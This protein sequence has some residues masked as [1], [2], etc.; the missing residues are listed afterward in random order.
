LVI[1]LTRDD[2]EKAIIKYVKED[3]L[4]YGR[5]GEFELKVTQGKSA[6]AKVDLV[7]IIPNIE[8]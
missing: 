1:N 4:G 8:E 5:T 6:S 3:I 7:K 2:L